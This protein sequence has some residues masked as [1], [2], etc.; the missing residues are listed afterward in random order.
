MDASKLE[1]SKTE[2]HSLD[3]DNEFV[4]DVVE[5]IEDF[6]AGRGESFDNKEDLMNYLK[7]L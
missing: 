5:G 4:S 6:K 2:V 7:S 3:L 1:T